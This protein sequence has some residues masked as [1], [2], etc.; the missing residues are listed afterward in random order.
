MMQFCSLIIRATEDL[1][2]SIL[3]D[4]FGEMGVY[5][6]NLIMQF[7]CAKFQ[8]SNLNFIFLPPTW[9]AILGGWGELSKNYLI[10]F[11]PPIECVSMQNL[12]SVAS[13]VSEKR[14]LDM[15]DRR[16]DGRTWLNRFFSSR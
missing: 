4:F 13:M 10:A 14:C 1:K 2:N 11:C 5:I 8:V 12:E 9:V 7:Y 6:K 3:G 16:T 15:T